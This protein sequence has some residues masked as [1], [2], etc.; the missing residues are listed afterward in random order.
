MHSKIA[1]LF[2]PKIDKS[3]IFF[4]SFLPVSQYMCQCHIQHI[5]ILEFWQSFHF[6]ESKA[7]HLFELLPYE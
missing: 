7:W 4:L 2:D 1:Q 6:I 3:L 5:P